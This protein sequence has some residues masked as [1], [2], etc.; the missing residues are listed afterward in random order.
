MRKRLLIV[1]GVVVVVMLVGAGALYAYDKGQRNRIAQ[2]ITVGGVAIGGLTPAQARD[3]LNRVY[4][5]RFSHPVVIG[6]R[7]R[8][9]GRRWVLLPRSARVEVNVDATVDDAM[10]RSRNGTIFGR[11][12][13][14]ITGGH[15]NAEIAPQVTFSRGPV[16]RLVSRVKR[17]LN[18]PARDASVSL[19]PGSVGLVSAQ[20][21]IAVRGRVLTAAIEHALADPGAPHRIGVPVRSVA[22]RVSTSRLAKQYP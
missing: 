4:V 19:Q 14:S 5:P 1:T 3:L 11:V 2:G 9:R 20:P 21:G 6:V 10:R 16:S 7:E 13:R 22:P 8:V 17:Q 12:W 18:R 15:V